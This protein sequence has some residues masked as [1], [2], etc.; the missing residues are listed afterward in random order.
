MGDR[1][2]RA[3]QSISEPKY[4]QIS[5]R[6]VIR[7]RVLAAIANVLLALLGLILFLF[8]FAGDW[9]PWPD[10]GWMLLV[11]FAA[12]KTLIQLVRF[13]CERIPRR[14]RNICLAAHVIVFGYG[15]V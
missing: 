12:I 9:S 13:R 7:L 4:V 6:I 11:M 2:N 15:L 14:A 10:A 3:M 1:C 5:K 8:A